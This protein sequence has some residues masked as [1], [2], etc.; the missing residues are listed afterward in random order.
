MWLCIIQIPLMKIISFKPA[1][2]RFYGKANPVKKSTIQSKQAPQKQKFLS[3]K[4]PEKDDLSRKPLKSIDINESSPPIITIRD[5]V[6][7]NRFCLRNF[8]YNSD[9]DPI[10]VSKIW[11][12]YQRQIFND[13]TKRDNDYANSR[14]NAIKFLLKLSTKLGIISQRP[15]YS[16]APLNRRM[17]TLTPPTRL[18][19]IY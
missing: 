9:I 6:T 8:E 3:R 10:F 18:P 1:I 5:S 12:S 11:S 2:W 15:D 16:L 17:A 7:E 4:K 19:F 13:S 14:R